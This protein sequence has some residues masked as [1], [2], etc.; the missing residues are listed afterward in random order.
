MGSH[1]SF[2]TMIRQGTRSKDAFTNLHDCL[3]CPCD[4]RTEVHAM[5]AFGLW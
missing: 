2:L 1:L 4:G 5:V 3:P